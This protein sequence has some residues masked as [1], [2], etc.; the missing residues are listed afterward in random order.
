MPSTVLYDAGGHRNIL[1]EEALAGESEVET[2]Q[3]LIIHHDGAIIL[4][5]GGHNVY[6]RVLAETGKQLG[7]S[8]LE[9]I[10][11]SHQDPDVVAAINGWLVASEATAYVSQLWLRFVPHFGLDR[12]VVSRLR[13]I[14]D[15][16]MI[17]DLRGCKLLFVP[18]HFLHSP[19]NFHVYDP[20]SHIL[21]T[22]D[23]GASMG[24]PE[25]EVRDFEAH[26]AYMEPFHR[27]YM[28]S[29]RALRAWVRMVRQLDVEIVAPQHGAMFVGKRMVDRFL[30][31]L[32]TLETGVDVVEPLFR[33][34]EH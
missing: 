6:A 27:R 14:P 34:P 17:L 16:G 1:I 18:A 3:H 2:N 24:T 12:L 4:D 31:W 32:E 25:R 15:E 21:Y 28:A 9:A 26:R 7:R 5:P 11:L 19:G 22:G 33:L 13:G 29:N 8:R 10:L 20:V 30:A 23:L